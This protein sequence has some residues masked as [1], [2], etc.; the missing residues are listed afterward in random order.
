M[1]DCGNDFLPTAGSPA[2]T[3]PS[4]VA[5][6]RRVDGSPV[7]TGAARTKIFTCFGPVTGSA[8]TGDAGASSIGTGPCRPGVP[9][10]RPRTGGAGDSDA[11]GEGEGVE[12]PSPWSRSVAFVVPGAGGSALGVSGNSGSRQ[13]FSD[14]RDFLLIAF[15]LVL[16][17]AAGTA[18]RRRHWGEVVGWLSSAGG[19]GRTVC[20]TEWGALLPF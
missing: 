11:T 2:G 12:S 3:G 15:Q 5:I 14:D 18:R 4:S 20:R 16:Q 19:L 9:T 1:L 8:V 7:P 6:L 17:L 13:R 10:R